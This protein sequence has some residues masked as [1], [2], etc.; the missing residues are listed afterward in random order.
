V[1]PQNGPSITVTK[2]THGWKFLTTHSGE[3]AAAAAADR[4]NQ[5]S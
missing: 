1:L 2:H 3:L 4:L 5:L